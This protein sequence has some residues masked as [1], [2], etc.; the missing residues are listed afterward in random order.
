[1]IKCKFKLKLNEYHF[2]LYANDDENDDANSNNIIF[3]IKGTKLYVFVTLS[4]KKLPKTFKT[5]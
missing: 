2:V 3:T 1:M 4:A 5:S